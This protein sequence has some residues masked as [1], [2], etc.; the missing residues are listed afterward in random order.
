[1]QLESNR[2]LIGFSLLFAICLIS[3]SFIFQTVFAANLTTSLIVG[4]AS[5]TVDTVTVNNATT[6]INLNSGST[7]N[8]GTTTVTINFSVTDNNGCSDV[9]SSGSLAILFYRT[10]I[11]SS[12]CNSSQSNL[13]CYKV[14]TSTNSCS[15]ANVNA[16]ATATVDVYYFANAT[17]ASSSFPSTDWRATVIATDGSAGSGFRDSSGIEV[18]TLVAIDVTTSSINYGTVTAGS[19][20]SSTNQ[21]ATTTNAGNASTT[22]QLS[23]QQTLKFGANAIATSSQRYATSAFTYAGAS[24]P[25]SDSATTVS[26]FLL[27]S[28]TSTTNVAGASFWGVSVSSSYP[29]GTYTGTTIF[30]ALFQP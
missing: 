8:N 6:T 22:L 5:P 30:G 27:T 4:N 26:G 23:A 2:S 21:T 17:D 13:N 11:T 19:D 20:T 12:S 3:A 28:P 29:T 18:N 25:L 9:F 10:T 16:N 1:M 15:G 14:T 24:V 7:L